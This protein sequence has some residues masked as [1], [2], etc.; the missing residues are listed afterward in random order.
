MSR[1]SNAEIS[2][3]RSV[4]MSRDRNVKMSQDRNVEMSRD[5]SADPYQDSN[6]EMSRDSSVSSSVKISSG[7]KNVIKWNITTTYILMKYNTTIF[8]F[9]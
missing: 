8:T 7:A 3:D 5:R 4:K 9:S 6:V 1:D 2:Q